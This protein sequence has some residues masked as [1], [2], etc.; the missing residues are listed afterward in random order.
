MTNYHLYKNYESAHKKDVRAVIELTNNHIASAS[1]DG[2]LKVW[3]TLT[4]ES[5]IVYTDK[6]K[7]NTDTGVTI[8][9]F[10]NSLCFDEESG[11]IY[12][13]SSDGTIKGFQAFDGNNDEPCIVL[14]NHTQNVCSL[15]LTSDFGDG[16]K[17]YMVSSSWDGTAIVWE[18]NTPKFHLKDPNSN[19]LPFWDIK[20]INKNTFI[21]CG[22]DKSVIVW[23]NDK[24]LKKVENAHKDVVRGIDVNLDTNEFVTCSND[25]LVKVWDLETLALKREMDGHLS[26]V[27]SVRYSKRDSST[28]ISCGEDRSLIIWDV[29]TGKSTDVVVTPAISVWC[30]ESIS[31]GDIC[32]GSSDGSVRL[33][34]TFPSRMASPQEINAFAESVKKTSVNESTINE[35]DILPYETI[36]NPG[37][38]DGQVVMV[39]HPQS[40]VIEAYQYSDLMSE[41]SKVGDVV[42]GASKEKNNKV[43]Y[44]GEMYDYVFDVALEQNA[45]SLKLPFNVNENVYAAAERFI[46]KNNLNLDHTEQIVN[47]LLKNTEVTN[48]HSSQ[49]QKPS[50]RY[51]VLPV[52]DSYLTFLQFKKEIIIKGI[53]NINARE[54]NKIDSNML[55]Q[56]DNALSN[57]AS[58]VS[59]LYDMCGFIRDN[60]KSNVL[61][62]DILRLIS[63][64]LPSSDNMKEYLWQGFSS[65]NWAIK[66]MVIRALV[67][68]FEN[69]EWGLMLM[70]DVQIHENLFEVIDLPSPEERK[71]FKQ[72]DNYLVAIATL[73]YNYSVFVI[74]YQKHELLHT[75]SDVINMKFGKDEAF[76]NN[77][78]AAYRLLLAYGNLSTVEPV[79]KQLA[80]SITWVQSIKTRYSHIKR[81]NDILNDL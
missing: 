38:K 62:Y 23:R 21:T 77:E 41:W 4:D 60:W 33:F 74:R 68:V 13:G 7:L 70:G 24:I 29:E 54:E 53:T 46:L 76:L 2:T 17:K 81:F 48:I 45:P 65:D 50:Q 3:N 55:A 22:A 63:A 32:I 69:K 14:T 49:T 15:S 72:L 20:V 28:V 19:G 9:V 42:S 58:N 8:E 47:F 5:L 25:G 11:I 78:E 75:L 34:S 80:K 52:V 64:Y 1:R 56:F 12:V 51:S 35:K 59:F 57:P 10:L 27:Y 16:T 43:E 26:F 44:E 31:N 18:N 39:K 30:L 36:L 67:N 79:L 61:A 66:M 40:G 71:T 37:K 6:G 73:C